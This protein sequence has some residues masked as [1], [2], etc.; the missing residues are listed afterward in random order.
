MLSGRFLRGWPL[1]PSE[2]YSYIMVLLNPN[3]GTLQ[4]FLHMVLLNPNKGT[5]QIS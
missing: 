2:K 5:L 1:E 3:K 4:I